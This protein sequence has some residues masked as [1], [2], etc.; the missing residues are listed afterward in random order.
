[1]MAFRNAVSSTTGFT[2]F[3]VLFGREMRTPL[4]TALTPRSTLPSSVK[5]YVND[6]LAKL[7][8]TNMLVSANR[9][10]EQARQKKRH[11]LKAKAPSFTVGNKVYVRNEAITKG[12]SKKLSPKFN[13]PF[14]IVDAGPNYTYQLKRLSDG[15]IFR[16][17]FN[18]SRLKLWHERNVRTSQQPNLEPQ[19]NDAAT[20]V[21]SNDEGSSLTNASQ[22][23]LPVKNK[24]VEKIVRMQCRGQT[25]WYRVKWVDL[26]WDQCSWVTS[27]SVPQDL[28]SKYHQKFNFKGRKRKR[29]LLSL[30]EE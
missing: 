11:D 20:R 4:D 22:P 30:R 9:I 14:E 25:R 16:N 8:L 18:A 10:G 27:D 17:L 26:P 24:V 3:Y 21:Q 29:R 15:K 13:G 6:L 2:P 23:Q 1:M 12:L 19:T 5:D 7:K 28:L